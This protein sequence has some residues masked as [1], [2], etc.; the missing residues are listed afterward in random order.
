MGKHRKRL[1]R[2]SPE[3]THKPV[4]PN[5]K[6]RERS[7]EQVHVDDLCIDRFGEEFNDAIERTE[8]ERAEVM[9]VV[10]RD[11]IFFSVCGS[12]R[13]RTLIVFIGI[14]SSVGGLVGWASHLL[15]T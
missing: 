6:W 15:R 5:S 10:E 8:I 1:T 3:A 13:R 11:G 9:I 7:T 12:V 4:A 2:E 14:V